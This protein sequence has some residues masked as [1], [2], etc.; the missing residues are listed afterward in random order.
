M[1]DGLVDTVDFLK[2][3]HPA[4]REPSQSTSKLKCPLASHQF[5]PATHVTVDPLNVSHGIG[6]K[7]L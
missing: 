3:G 4:E 6:D 2:L 5:Q 7:V 1:V